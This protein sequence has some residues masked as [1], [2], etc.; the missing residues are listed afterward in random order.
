M[1][2]RGD[3][4]VFTAFA[5]ALMSIPVQAQDDLLDTVPVNAQA[6][7]FRQLLGVEVT[8]TAIISSTPK[9]ANACR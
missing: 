3:Y 8:G 5:A 6:T 4:P 9:P 2:F 7:P 1:V